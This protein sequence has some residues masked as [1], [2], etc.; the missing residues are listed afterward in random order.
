MSLFISSRTPEGEPNRCPLCGASI[1][2]EPSQ[3]AGDA[4]C[5]NCGVLLWFIKTLE[6]ARYYDYEVIAPLRERIA[7]VL[8]DNLGVSKSELS[9]MTLVGT[10]LGLDSLD[11]VELIMELEDDFDVSLPEHLTDQIRTIADLIAFLEMYAR[12]KPPV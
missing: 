2:L 8:C 10:E 11:L 7:K 1:C 9:D 3:P 6:G 4:P 5:P 12:K